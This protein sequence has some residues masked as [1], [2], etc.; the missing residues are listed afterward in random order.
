[1]QM[2][3]SLPVDYSGGHIDTV[4]KNE[5][6]TAKWFCEEVRGRE[7]HQGEDQHHAVVPVKGG[8]QSPLLT[9]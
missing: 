7:E 8:G 3:E 5:P 2:W 6:D 9:Y 4:G 1:M